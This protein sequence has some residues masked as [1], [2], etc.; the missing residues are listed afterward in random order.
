MLMQAI[1]H[2]GCTDT[3]R[4][5]AL[6]V[7]FA[8]E[9]PCRIGDSNP[10][11][12]C[13]WLLSRTLCHVNYSHPYTRRERCVLISCCC[14]FLQGRAY[15]F[16][17]VVVFAGRSVLICCLFFLQGRAYSFVAFLQ[18]RAYSFVAFLQRRAYSFV[19]FCRE[20]RTHLLL[21]LQG[22]AYSAVVLFSKEERTRCCFLARRSV[23]VCCCFLAGKSV[24]AERVPVQEVK[25]QLSG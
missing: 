11:Q 4:E 23:L 18:E 6:E 24:G 22:R 20:E 8:R 13:G 17:V 12:Y 14:C 25:G 9:I 1:V 10:R 16:V 2:G 15:S 19:V 3:V 21:F 5:S 7:D